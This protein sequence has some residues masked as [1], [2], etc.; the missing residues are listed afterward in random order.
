MKRLT[1]ILFLLLYLLSTL[2]M[3]A[4]LHYCG[5][6]F[7]ELE[8]NSNSKLECCCDTE[9]EQSDCCSD[10]LIVV[11]SID[12][13]QLISLNNLQQNPPQIQSSSLFSTLQTSNRNLYLVTRL[14]DYH[15]PPPLYPHLPLFIRVRSL[16]V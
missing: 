13:H 16:L 1:S 5:D 3:S 7:E 15:A 2:G 14:S 8:I 4:K 12:F 11:Q 10:Q 6:N 9:T